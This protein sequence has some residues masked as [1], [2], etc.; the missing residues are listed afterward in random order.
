MIATPMRQTLGSEAPRTYAVAM[1]GL[2]IDLRS[3]L[4]RLDGLAGDLDGLYDE[5]E[6]LPTLQYDLHRASELVAGLEPPHGSEVVHEE[7][8]EAL[9]EARETTADIAEALDQGGVEA[10]APLVWEWRGVLFR[11]R[12]AR[13]RLERPQPVASAAAAPGAAPAGQPVPFFAAGAVAVGS[14][15]VLFAALLGLWLLV[16]LVLAGTGAAAVLLRP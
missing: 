11:V 15:L 5:R 7:L 16:A 1:A 3:A 9:A 10:A 2:W 14:G 13:V 8:S 6:T 4:A 12:L